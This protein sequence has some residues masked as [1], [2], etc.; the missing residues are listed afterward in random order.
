MNKGETW[1][2]FL[3]VL[4][5]SQHPVLDGKNLDPHSSMA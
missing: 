2:I 4:D 3:N 5:I 1:K